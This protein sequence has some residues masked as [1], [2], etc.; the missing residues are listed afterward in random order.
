VIIIFISI[1]NIKISLNVYQ[2]G[3]FLFECPEFAATLCFDAQKK[4]NSNASDIPVLLLLSY[5]I[6]TIG[7]AAVKGSE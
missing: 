3:Y 1:L 5:E 7:I 2:L 4:R 6:F